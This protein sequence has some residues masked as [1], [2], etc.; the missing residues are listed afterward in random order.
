MKALIP[1][2]EDGRLVLPEAMLKSLG[3]EGKGMVR[4]TAADGH[5]EL[6]PVVEKP[7]LTKKVGRLLVIERTGESFDAV[8]A[9]E[10][11]RQER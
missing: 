9:L 6:E 7:V 2:D 5:V 8:S 4:A 1:V 11:S 10:S 3:I